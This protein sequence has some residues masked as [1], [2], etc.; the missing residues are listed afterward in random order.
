[1]TC[2]KAEVGWSNPARWPHMGHV[3][4]LFSSLPLPD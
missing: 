2:G 1:M 4:R 3:N